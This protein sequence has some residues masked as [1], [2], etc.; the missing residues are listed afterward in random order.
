M[1]T[2]VLVLRHL[3]DNHSF[4]GIVYFITLNLQK[5]KKLPLQTV[6]LRVLKFLSRS[7]SD[8]GTLDQ[9]TD[10]KHKLYQIIVTVYRCYYLVFHKLVKLFIYFI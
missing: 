8:Q 10:L 1:I 7:N 9:R 2:L 6:L 5:S 3:I 4:H